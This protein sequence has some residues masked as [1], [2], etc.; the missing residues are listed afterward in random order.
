MPV[1]K[2]KLTLQGAALL[3]KPNIEVINTQP[4]GLTVTNS[5]K[6]PVTV[7]SA[8]T[9]IDASSRT[10]AANIT[11]NNL[12]NTILGG[13]GNDSLSGGAGKDIFIYRPNEGTD[14][15]YDYAAGDMLKI[16]KSNGTEGGTFTSSS[17]KSNNLT[18]A[19][20]GGGKVILSGVSAKDTFNINGKNYS[21]SGNKLK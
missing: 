16:L 18:L 14:T 5:S 17:F 11:G 21:I 15:I 4:T 9:V 1:G 6:S 10:K 20:S 8:I 3:L 19:I 12:A 13:T 7:G 2:E